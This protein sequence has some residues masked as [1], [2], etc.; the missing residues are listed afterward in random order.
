MG[1]VGNPLEATWLYHEMGRCYLETGD[2]VKARDCGYKSLQTASFDRS[3]QLNAGML[4][5]QAEGDR[6]VHEKM[7]MIRWLYHRVIWL[8]GWNEQSC[9]TSLS[10][11]QKHILHPRIRAAKK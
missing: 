8:Y 9:P 5:A 10:F 11:I 2:Y 7:V 3:W 6:M 4:L 1:L